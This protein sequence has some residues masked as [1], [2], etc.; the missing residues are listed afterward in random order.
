MTAHGAE[1]RTNC[2]NPNGL[3]VLHR[4]K[5]LVRETIFCRK[6]ARLPVVRLFA[7]YANF[8]LFQIGSEIF[9]PYG[10]CRK[11]FSLKVLFR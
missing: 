8:S 5:V 4:S 10:Y 1:F 7:P 3:C 6:T 11:S 2:G 9:A